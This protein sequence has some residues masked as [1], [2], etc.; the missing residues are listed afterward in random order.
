MELF[1]EVRDHYFNCFPSH[2]RNSYKVNTIF[3]SKNTLRFPISIKDIGVN[4][5]T[6]ITSLPVSFVGLFVVVI[7]TTLL[8]NTW[9]SLQELIVDVKDMFESISYLVCEDILLTNEQSYS[10]QLAVTNALAQ[11][12]KCSY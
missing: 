7:N 9:L 2:V 1:T 5:K 4:L 8:E 3:Y 6:D 12:C 10:Q 11:K